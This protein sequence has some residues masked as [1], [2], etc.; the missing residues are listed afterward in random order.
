MNWEEEGTSAVS[1][2]V[3]NSPGLETNGIVMQREFLV[4]VTL[5]WKCIFPVFEPGVP[6][7]LYREVIDAP[8]KGV[9]WVVPS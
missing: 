3:L 2:S 5:V 8:R 6:T 1:D 7:G 4:F 9:A